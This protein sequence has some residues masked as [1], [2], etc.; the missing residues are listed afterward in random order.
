[1]GDSST[2]HRD[3]GNVTRVIKCH[4]NHIISGILW[5][6]EIKCIELIIT[7][8]VRA[9]HQQIKDLLRLGILRGKMLLPVTG[10]YLFQMMGY[11]E[12]RAEFIVGCAIS[13]CDCSSSRSFS[14]F[15]LIWIS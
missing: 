3:S 13:F 9:Q 1:M 11:E 14:S 12:C 2:F 5:Q 8:P 6:G 4:A 15:D 7:A 10:I